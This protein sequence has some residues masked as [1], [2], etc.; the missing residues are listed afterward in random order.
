MNKAAVSFGAVSLGVILGL[1]AAPAVAATAQQ[2]LDAIEEGTKSINLAA[3]QAGAGAVSTYVDLRNG[4]GLC[5]R[6]VRTWTQLNNTRFSLEESFQNS[7]DGQAAT[8]SQTCSVPSERVFEWSNRELRL[9]RRVYKDLGGNTLSDWRFSPGIR[10][11]QSVMRPG[12]SYTDM[13]TA[14][15]A[16]NGAT[17]YTLWTT[18]YSAMLGSVTTPYETKNSCIGLHLETAEE[19]I[20]QNLAFCA[21]DDSTF[22]TMILQETTPSYTKYW[23]RM[24]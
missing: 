14:T 7:S 12:A 9:I 23:V 13:V 19:G 3:L 5:D 2:R 4:S 1:V 8:P 16:L 18:Q 11:Y 22:G 6:M 20:L 10:I 17:G 15:N 21:N 24:P